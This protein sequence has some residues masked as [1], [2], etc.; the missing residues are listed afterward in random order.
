MTPRTT[1]LRP[2]LLIVSLALAGAGCRPG[3]DAPA[4]VASGPTATPPAASPKATQEGATRE[5]A[6]REA[7][8]P[9][10]TEAARPRG[11][12]EV[13]LVERDRKARQRLA[14]VQAEARETARRVASNGRPPAPALDP[15]V[16][17]SARRGTP[18]PA[19]ESG[20]AETRLLGICSYTESAV[21]CWD[22]KGAPAPALEPT[23][24]NLLR[25]GSD[26]GTRMRYGYKNRVLV[27]SGPQQANVSYRNPE[28][29]GNGGSFETRSVNDSFGPKVE[30]VFASTSPGNPTGSVLVRVQPYDVRPRTGTLPKKAGAS[31]TVDGVKVS[32]GS[33]AKIGPGDPYA[34]FGM[35]GMVGPDSPKPP[36]WRASLTWDKAGNPDAG[37]SIAPVGLDG[38][39]IQAV[40]GAGKPKAPARDPRGYPMMN[41]SVSQPV[42]RGSGEDY[43][44][45]LS[46]DPAYVKGFLV[47]VTRAR[48]T[49]FRDI[50]L[51]PKR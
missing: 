49:L 35:G 46:V 20:D 12:T 9:P 43:D 18:P 13:D 6:T 21:R 30:A 23:V 36:H 28:A 5:G 4:P 51:D 1:P 25:S 42:G 33:V 48:T 24:D 31:V 22:P 7:A 29:D 45:M 14:E 17:A 26:S 19:S 8:S 40:D 50:P 15:R 47:S 44:L 32:L 16:V 34:N 38:R 27:F 3:E 10:I 2:A 11:A 41:M 39:P 37:Y